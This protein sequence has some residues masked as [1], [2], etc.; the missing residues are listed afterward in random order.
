MKKEHWLY[1]II[2]LLAIW[3]I[4]SYATAPKS[5]A[6]TTS[7]TITDS[8]E[9]TT[10]ET[11]GTNTI[12][13]IESPLTGGSAG[14]N[15][16]TLTNSAPISSAIL[17]SNQI[18]GGMVK[19]DN[20]ALTFDGWVVIHED[21]NGA[22]GNVLGAQ[23]FDMGTY[24]GGQVELQRNTVAGGKYYAML[25][26]DNGNKLFDLKDDAVTMDGDTAVM[27]TFIAQ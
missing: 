18:A 12:S 23:R 1:I 8:S 13:A 24:A 6:P 7:D 20:V 5:E 19:I 3:I 4:A 10:I 22:P 9:A 14:P 15:K 26:V 27:A 17:V 2:A 16:G 11:P 21:R 25:H